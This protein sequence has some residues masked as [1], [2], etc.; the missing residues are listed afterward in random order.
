MNMADVRCVWRTEYLAEGAVMDRKEFEE[1]AEIASRLTRVA[2]IG[3]SD[4]A[5][6]RRTS[7][8]QLYS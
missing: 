8:A 5:V 7:I 4:L 3:M 6:R 1:L 2:I